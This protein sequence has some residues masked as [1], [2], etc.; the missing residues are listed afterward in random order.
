MANEEKENM[1]EQG[2]KPKIAYSNLPANSHKSK[3][4]KGP[5]PKDVK[6][7]ISGEVVER[8]K[9]LTK[10][11]AE[12]F[13]GEDARSV[14]GYI[15]FEVII[16]AAK[17]MISDAV[18]QGIERMLFGDGYSSRRRS[19]QGYT[20]YNRIHGSA[21][22]AGRGDERRAISQRG[23][24]THD[25]KEIVLSTRAEAEE[26]LDRLSDL[27]SDYDVALVSDL[28]D[29]VGITGSFTDDKWGWTSLAG[30][31]VQPVRGG[32]LLNLPRTQ[33]ID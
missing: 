26:V 7:V 25:F 8:K 30:S 16:P 11:I 27:I 22:T 24:A 14:G 6:K 9:P 23:R 13:A 15:L 18:S 2:D 21:Q 19:S 33:S 20:P 10:R 3:D 31:S 17:T 1:A 5:P 4:P 28:Y 12:T 29:L 32:Y